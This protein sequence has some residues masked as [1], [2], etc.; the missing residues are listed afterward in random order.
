[1]K[2]IE[3]AA[4]D[5]EYVEV[6][7]GRGS[8]EAGS[9]DCFQLIEAGFKLTDVIQVLMSLGLLKNHHVMK[10]IIGMTLPTL[11]RKAT[12]PSKTLDSTHSERLFRFAAL[13]TRAE[14]VFGD[15]PSALDWI[16]KP[17]LG[18]EGYSPLDL[19]ANSVGYNIVL[20]FL[21][22]IEYGVYH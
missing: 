4:I 14:E 21:G 17:A 22:R 3:D 10:Q 8:G 6:L 9:L 16:V 12:D 2:V 18:L 11:Q 15:K 5:S 1:M 19:L 20:T 7:L 13:T